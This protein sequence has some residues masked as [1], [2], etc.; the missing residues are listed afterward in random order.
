MQKSKNNPTAQAILDFWIDEVGPK[1]WYEAD[2]AV[3]AEIGARFGD[4]HHMAAKGQLSDW[5]E[6]ANGSLALL[7]LL[8]QFSRNMFRGD[9]KSFASDPLAREIARSAIARDQDQQIAGREQQFFYLPFTHS[10]DLTD[11]DY[12]V[13]LNQTRFAH[14]SDDALHARAHREIIRRFGRFPFRNDALGRVSSDEEKTF[15]ADG[16]YRSVVNELQ[17][18]KPE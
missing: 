6:T 12:G 4:A 15:M 13:E 16:G 3:D 5:Q 1:G 9:A 17:A 8:D 14:N 7:I 18:V 10:E 2:D 11:Q